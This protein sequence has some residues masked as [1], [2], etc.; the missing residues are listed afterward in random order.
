[1]PWERTCGKDDCQL[2]RLKGIRAI[3]YTSDVI[4]AKSAFSELKSI[5]D[6]FM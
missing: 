5:R 3:G 4:K 1:M 6:Q 2:M